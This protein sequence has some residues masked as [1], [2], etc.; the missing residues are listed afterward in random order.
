MKELDYFGL[1]P[2][3]KCPEKKSFF[4]DGIELYTSAGQPRSDGELIRSL[5]INDLQNFKHICT[6]IVI[7]TL[8]THTCGC[9]NPPGWFLH[10][11]FLTEGRPPGY[12]GSMSSTVVPLM[13]CVH[14]CAAFC[15]VGDLG[16]RKNKAFCKFYIWRKQSELP[17][18]KN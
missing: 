4:F 10:K 14:R 6:H 15:L 5:Q 11:P 9:P 16:T 17:A 8:G 3:F 2:F 18:H 13:Q 7:Y 1:L 12:R